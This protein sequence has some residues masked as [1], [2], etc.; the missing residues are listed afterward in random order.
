MPSAMTL[1]ELVDVA[2]LG[3][4]H[5]AGPA[6]AGQA[7]RWAHVTELVRPG[8]YLRGGEIV[9]TVGSALRG[10]DACDA[11]AAELAAAGVTALAFGIGDVHDEP[12]V[13]LVTACRNH[14]I[15]L[16]TVPHGVPFQSL[17]E[18]VTEHRIATRLAE[19]RRGGHLVG[20]LL[21][22]MAAGV[23][24]EDG[25][26][27]VADELG[28]GL[29]VI[30]STGHV[31]AVAGDVS[32]PAVATVDVPGD[33]AARLVWHA[34]AGD[35]DRV[36]PEALRELVRPLAVWRHERADALLRSEQDLGRLVRL[37]LEG[38]AEPSAIGGHLGDPL[39]SVTATLWRSAD[40]A[41]VRR[42]FPGQ[43]RAALDEGMLVLVTDSAAAQALAVTRRLPCGIG[44]TV[45]LRD[46]R[47]S[48]REAHGALALSVRRG[49]PVTS[50]ELATLDALLDRVP[51]DSLRPF[52]DQLLV[53][54][55]AHDKASG[56]DLLAT[57]RTFLDGGA[58]VVPVARAMFLHPN[59]LR[60]RLGRMTELTGRNP[61][62][63]VD[64]TA[65]LVA[66]RA[67]ERLPRR[68]S[69]D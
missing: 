19:E 25:L 62:D 29:V 49:E 41:E 66:L 57:L 2:E 16:V 51:D 23:P 6:P 45:A 28:G 8:P 35:P 5:A 43:A 65:F 30:D 38:L 56:S 47:R 48:V 40:A 24:P 27:R 54:L 17:T 14:A 13:E 59:T 22:A 32:S 15:P 69:A 1:A 31:E 10:P 52:V 33:P 55:A 11:F 61:L 21:D 39:G 50:A 7:V 68:G 53:P 58:A 42:L 26:A 34:P 12:P 67:G 60:H 4:A 3:L 63:Q 18:L 9:L 20:L 36:S 44:E 64:R 46:I 37:V